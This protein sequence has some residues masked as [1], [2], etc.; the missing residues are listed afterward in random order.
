MSYF[1]LSGSFGNKRREFPPIVICELAQEAKRNSTMQ[2]AFSGLFVQ[3]LTIGAGV[4]A[5]C[6][7]VRAFDRPG[8]FPFHLH[9]PLPS[10]GCRTTDRQT[11]AGNSF[12]PGLSLVHGS[13]QL[14]FC[15]APLLTSHGLVHKTILTDASIAVLWSFYRK[16]G[17]AVAFGATTSISSCS[18][19][20]SLRGFL[21]L[22]WSM[23]QH[24]GDYPAVHT[25][26]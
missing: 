7:H 26:L 3:P 14:G 10:I 15:G 16:R 4:L 13:D 24:A 11:Y 22:R 2:N 18:I 5:A 17:R 1:A 19:L 21:S 9:A 23:D 20:L 8:P 25:T 12:L 6:R